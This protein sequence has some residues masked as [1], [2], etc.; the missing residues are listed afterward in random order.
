MAVE[1]TA[2]TLNSYRSLECDLET[3]RASLKAENHFNRKT[4]LK[5]EIQQI[6][7]SMDTIAQQL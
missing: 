4:A 5:L 6:K 2:Q 7:Q 3:L 1:E